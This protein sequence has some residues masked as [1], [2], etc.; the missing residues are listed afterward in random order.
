[1]TAFLRQAFTVAPLCVIAVISLA[2]V[3]AQQP[4]TRSTDVLPALLQ[5][6]RGLRMAMEHSA[7]I[8]PRIQLTLARLNIE[9]QRIAQL[10]AQFDR[11]HQEVANLG[12]SQGRFADSLE[13]TERELQT[14]AD[15]KRRREL[16]VA[17]RDVKQQLKAS[18]ASEQAART[19]END[20]LQALTTEQNRWTEL[21][22]RLDE[23]ERLLAP[24]R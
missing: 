13:E 10:A 15:E 9:E 6:V 22:A 23:L 12:V 18:T 2:S 3:G 8:A 14:T 7:S 5:E 17:I 20:A 24:V 1:M 19:R 11:A 16:E 21:N 4:G